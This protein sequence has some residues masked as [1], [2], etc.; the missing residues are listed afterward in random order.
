MGGH[1]CALNTDRVF[2][3]R[4][5]F[6]K[7]HFVN[8]LTLSILF[9]CVNSYWIGGLLMV[10]VD[11]NGEHCDVKNIKWWYWQVGKWKYN[12]DNYV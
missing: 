10:T 2:G 11:V 3:G 9:N 4:S 5:D 12:D 6:I 1:H 8:R 7:K